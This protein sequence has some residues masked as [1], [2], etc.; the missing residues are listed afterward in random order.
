ML[1]YRQKIDFI[2]TVIVTSATYAFPLAYPTRTDLGKLDKVYAEICRNR[3]WD[4]QAPA[5]QPWFLKTD[6]K[7]ELGCHPCKL[8]IASWI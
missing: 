6:T 7:V 3:H 4:C 8:N 5:Q 2:N 1:S